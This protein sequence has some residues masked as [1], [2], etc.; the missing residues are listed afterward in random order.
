LKK[1]SLTGGPKSSGQLKQDLAPALLALA[2][3]FSIEE[4]NITG[5]KLGNKGLFALAR[6]LQT[7][8]SL[9]ADIFLSQSLFFYYNNIK[10]VHCLFLMMDFNKHHS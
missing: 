4:L 5:H 8:T 6:A 1:L 3:N 7:N 9:K 10:K 2:Q